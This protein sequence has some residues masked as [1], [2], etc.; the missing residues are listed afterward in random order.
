MLNE[1][2]PKNLTKSAFSHENNVKYSKF[3]FGRLWNF[4]L[5]GVGFCFKNAFSSIKKEIKD[6]RLKAS[7]IRLDLNLYEI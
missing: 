5:K 1:S 2:A 3:K 4:Y 7:H 6:L